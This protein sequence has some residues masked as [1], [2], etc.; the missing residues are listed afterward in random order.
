VVPT[1]L[2]QTEKTETEKTDADPDEK[3]EAEEK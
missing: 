2:G 3:S 1:A